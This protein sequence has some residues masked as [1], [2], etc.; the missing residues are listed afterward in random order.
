MRFILDYNAQLF[1][2]WTP[3]LVSALHLLPL[4]VILVDHE[5]AI[6]VKVGVVPLVAMIRGEVDALETGNL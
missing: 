1:L 2:K 3:V 6:V 4:V 5:E